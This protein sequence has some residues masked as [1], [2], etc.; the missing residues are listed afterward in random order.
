MDKR[1]LEGFLY[2]FLM[3]LTAVV[4]FLLGAKYAFLF[5]TLPEQETSFVLIPGNDSVEQTP[6]QN[7]IDLNTA[8][9]EELMRV[10]GIGQTFAERIVAYREE[11]GRFT[12]LEQLLEVEGIGKTRYAEWSVYFTVK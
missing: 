9:V 5:G 7:S 11:I 4:F 2:G 6:S 8:T 10:P 12:S 1:R 3:L